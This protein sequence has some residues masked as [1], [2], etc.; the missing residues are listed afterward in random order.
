M[1]FP[2][3]RLKMTLGRQLKVLEDRGNIGFD[4]CVELYLSVQPAVKDI[5]GDTTRFAADS[6]GQTS[7]T[8]GQC[9]LAT[10]F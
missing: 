10:K 1:H 5:S 7:S 3:N 8:A 9:P 6:S 2:E 4:L